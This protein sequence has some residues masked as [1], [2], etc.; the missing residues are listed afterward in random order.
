MSKTDN[1]WRKTQSVSIHF[2]NWIV[3]NISVIELSDLAKKNFAPAGSAPVVSILDERHI[4][5]PDRR[6]SKTLLAIN[7]NC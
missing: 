7:E 4:I 2:L 1:K 3:R 5:T 6:Q